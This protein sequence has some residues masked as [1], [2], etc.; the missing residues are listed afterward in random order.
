MQ[1]LE[2][3]RSAWAWTGLEPKELVAENEFGNLIVKDES[4]RFWRICPEEL[5]CDV[6]AEE[7]ASL[8]ALFLDIEFQED[9]SMDRLVA[10]A[11]QCVGPLAEGRKYCLKIPGMLG[12]QYREENLASLSFTELVSF[13]GHVAQQIK[14]LPDGTKVNFRFDDD[15]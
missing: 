11:V 10:L 8:D 5:S 14:D 2:T 12:G 3:V 15:A 13:A 6:V 4:G 1:L 9:W 7:R